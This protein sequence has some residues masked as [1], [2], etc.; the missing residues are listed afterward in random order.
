MTWRLSYTTAAT[1]DLRKL[2]PEVA[3]RI[4][5]ALDEFAANGTGDVKKLQGLNPPRW[6]LRV[7]D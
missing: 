6:R 7:G 1:R 4:V 3:G 2:G 5:A